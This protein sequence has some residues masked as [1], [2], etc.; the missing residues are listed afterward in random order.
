MKDQT[1][2]NIL[3]DLLLEDL[4]EANIEE[5]LG[6]AK[7]KLRKFKFKW[8]ASF[9]VEFQEMLGRLR[10]LLTKNKEKVETKEGFLEILL[11]ACYPG[12]RERVFRYFKRALIK[13]RRELFFKK[14]GETLGETIKKARRGN[15][16]SLWRL[17]E[18]D[19]TFLF[20][21]W[22][23]GEVLGATWRDDK[24]FLGR[25]GNAISKTR[26]P[27]GETRIRVGT[28]NQFLTTLFFLGHLAFFEGVGQLNKTKLMNIWLDALY[29]EDMFRS[30][31]FNYFLK[32]L[33][34]HN[35]L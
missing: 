30:A 9:D 19:I 28:L 18:W 22:V 2:S 14:Y 23:K 6:D 33:K 20:K 17:I 1:Q 11:E 4:S 25:L 7:S 27:F 31:D 5:L 10:T 29:E 15:H 13:R 26:P 12:F 35:L 32:F 21:K 16:R 24:V 8:T 3:T 34:R